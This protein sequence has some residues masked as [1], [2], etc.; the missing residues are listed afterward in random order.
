MRLLALLLTVSSLALA[1][2][3]DEGGAT[4][5]AP[6]DPAPIHGD[7]VAKV[8][9][10]FERS[11]DCK[12]AQGASRWGCSVGSYRCQG[13]VVDRGWSVSCAKPGRS[14]VFRIQPG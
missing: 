2:C 7:E 14:I 12:P 4:T 1:G 10:A 3:G 8:Q 11:E 5:S 9:S 13:V 6:V